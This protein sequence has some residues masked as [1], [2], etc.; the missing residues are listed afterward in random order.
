MITAVEILRRR[1][2][3]AVEQVGSTNRAPKPWSDIEPEQDGNLRPA[4]AVF[5]RVAEKLNRKEMIAELRKIAERITEHHEGQDKKGEARVFTD[6][7]EALG[8]LEELEPG[9]SGPLGLSLWQRAEVPV[10]RIQNELRS[11]LPDE[12]PMDEEVLT[13][14]ARILLR[15]RARAWVARARELDRETEQKAEEEGEQKEASP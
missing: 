1:L 2:L 11:A 14:A 12:P 13:Q 3:E 4:A 7:A 6:A 5:E 15:T 10:G 9:K 8:K